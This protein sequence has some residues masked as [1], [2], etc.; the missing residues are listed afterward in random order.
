[1]D[2]MALRVIW[3]CDAALTL[4]AVVQ[5]LVHDWQIRCTYNNFCY[6]G[7]VNTSGSKTVFPLT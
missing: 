7:V 1:M 6:P 4:K 5:N 3:G 2:G